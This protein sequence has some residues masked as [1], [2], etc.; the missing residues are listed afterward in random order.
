MNIPLQLP[1]K[2]RRA[3]NILLVVLIV[4]CPSAGILSASP[5][6]NAA[7]G[8]MQASPRVTADGKGGTNIDMPLINGLRPG[9]ADTAGPG[10]QTGMDSPRIRLALVGDMML[11]RGPGRLIAAGKSPEVFSPGRAL[12]AGSDM[13]VGNLECA[14]SDKGEPAV[15][16]FRFRAPVAA[17]TALADAGYTIVTLANNHAMDY[18]PQALLDTIRRLQAVGIRTVGAGSND[19]EARKPLVVE[20]GSMRIAFLGYADV[21]VESSGFSIRSWEAGPVKPGIAIAR[22]ADIAEDVRQAATLADAVIVLLHAGVEG[23]AT[24]SVSQRKLAGAAIDAGATIVACSH[25]HVAGGGEWRKDSYIAW[26][27][28]NWIFDGFEPGK[29]SGAVLRAVL[30][31]GYPDK[32]ATIVALELLPKPAAGHLKSAP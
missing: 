30:Q 26:G 3:R 8:R 22:E 13:V 27:L 18:G 14:I 20:R 29:E 16:G 28:G 31:S 17:A 32:K 5:P 23:F 1:L 6:G 21:P 19:R 10:T 9:S 24:P 15:K 12:I 11:A 25:S 4:A 2:A 7:S